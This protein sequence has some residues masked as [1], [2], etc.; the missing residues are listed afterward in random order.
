MERLVFVAEHC[1]RRLPLLMLAVSVLVVTPHSA[2]SQQCDPPRPCGVPY[3]SYACENVTC[4]C[5]YDP[6]IGSICGDTRV[7]VMGPFTWNATSLLKKCLTQQYFNCAQIWPCVPENPPCS[8]HP[9]C[10]QLDFIGNYVQSLGYQPEE[11]CGGGPP[12]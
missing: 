2:E 7:R 8:T 10:T 6:E 1:T 9:T 11:S 5:W 3:P 4:A 12:G